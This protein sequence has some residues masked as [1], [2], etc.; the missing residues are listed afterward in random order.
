MFVLANNREAHGAAIAAGYNLLLGRTPVA[1]N[2]ALLEDS[3]WWPRERVL[4]HQWQKLE[5]LVRHA[6]QHVPFYRDAMHR[7]EMTPDDVRTPADFAKLPVLTK[8]DLNQHQPDLFATN[9]DPARLIKTASGG[10]TGVPVTVYHD[11][12]FEIGRAHV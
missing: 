12:E 7:L 6:Y 8:A 2:A 11:P 5:R 3:Q 10:S 1:R 9:A 4:H